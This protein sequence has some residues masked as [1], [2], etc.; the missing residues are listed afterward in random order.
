[1]LR[2]PAVIV[3]TSVAWKITKTPSRGRGFES[4]DDPLS[5]LAKAAFD[6]LQ[7]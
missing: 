7:K 1:M 6:L 4:G 3:E 2:S 5:T